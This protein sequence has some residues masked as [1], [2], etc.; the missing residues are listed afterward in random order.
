VTEAFASASAPRPA[1]A[2]YADAH[3]DHD[4]AF[5]LPPRT[6]RRRGLDIVGRGADL[7]H[8]RG[9][10]LALTVLLFTAVGGYGSAIGG[11]YDDFVACNGEPQDVLARV[12]GFGVDEITITGQRELYYPDILAASGVSDRDSLLFLDVHEVRARLLAVPMVKEASVRKFYPDRLV[13]EVVEREP[14]ALWQK[15]GQVFLISADGKAIDA[16]RDDRFAHLPFVVGEGANLRVAEFQKIV[17]AAGD[18]KSKIRA[19]VLVTNRRWN[20]KLTTGVDVK[21]PERQPERAV[22]S[23]ARLAKEQKIIEKDLI[24]IDLRTPGRL[25]ARLSE[26]S[27]AVRNEINAKKPQRRGA[28]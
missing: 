8:R 19:G 23:L 3:A 28:V 9:V 25:A 27:A 2:G 1:W 13:V 20:L 18:L 5:R 6:R 7:M 17:D 14:H 4:P 12:F 11:G 15:D 22:A 26:E 21:L 10:G 24:S 16:L